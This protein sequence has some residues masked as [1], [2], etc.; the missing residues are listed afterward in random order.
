M[1]RG[2]SHSGQGSWGMGWQWFGADGLWQATPF[3]PL[4]WLLRVSGCHW[5]WFLSLSLLNPTTAKF[6]TRYLGE[7]P[8]LTFLSIFSSCL[9]YIC[10]HKQIHLYTHLQVRAVTTICLDLKWTKVCSGYQSSL[11][12]N[13]VSRHCPPQIVNISPLSYSS[14]DLAQTSSENPSLFSSKFKPSSSPSVY[15]C[16]LRKKK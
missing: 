10:L 16:I 14:Q 9:E 15:V 8:L 12:P 11:P 6:C 4:S 2:E 3:L 13:P 7:A 5:L 1:P